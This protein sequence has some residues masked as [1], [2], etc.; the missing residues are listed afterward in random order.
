MIILCK[1]I[2]L[3]RVKNDNLTF[4]SYIIL[5]AYPFRLFLFVCESWHMYKKKKI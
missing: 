2:V 3:C 4:S 1:N 5:Q